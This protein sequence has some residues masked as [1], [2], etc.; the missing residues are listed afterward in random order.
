MLPREEE[1][2]LSAQVQTK[3]INAACCCALKNPQWP[4]STATGTRRLCWYLLSNHILSMH[5]DVR[6]I[7][8]KLLNL[9][10]KVSK[11]EQIDHSTQREVL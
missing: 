11:R 4:G 6:Q 8:V 5:T 9:K 2:A 7:S 1:D 3:G 10:E